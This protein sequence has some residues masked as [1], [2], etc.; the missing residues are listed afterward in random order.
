MVGFYRS[1][2]L[3]AWLRSY[4]WFRVILATEFDIGFG[5]IELKRTVG[6]YLALCH[7]HYLIVITLFA[8]FPDFMRDVA[9]RD[10]SSK[11]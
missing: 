3:T 6:P 9:R 10:K 2:E 8:Q 5:S 1:V 4:E 11:T 7:S